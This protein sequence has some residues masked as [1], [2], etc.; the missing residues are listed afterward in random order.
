MTHPSPESRSRSSARWSATWPF[1]SGLGITGSTIA[2][3][4]LGIAELVPLIAF[5]LW[6]VALTDAVD[7]RRMV[8]LTKVVCH[9]P[10][11]RKASFRGIGEG[12]RYAMSLKEWVRT[13]AVETP[14]MLFAMPA[15]LHPAMAKDVFEE[16]SASG[17]LDASEALNCC[18]PS[19]NHS[20]ETRVP[21][22]SPASG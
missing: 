21:R 17:S 8:L 6:G 15:A 18:S 19:S 2:V 3:G 9:P 1:R 5:G 10:G 7:P 11:R 12:L 22:W 16:P 14:A 13:Y 20:V 4:L